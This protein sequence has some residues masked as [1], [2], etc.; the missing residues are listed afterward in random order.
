MLVL[1]HD[2]RISIRLLH[3]T[4]VRQ[5]G[6]NNSAFV[7]LSLELFLLIIALKDIKKVDI[8][9]FKGQTNSH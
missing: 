9:V 6:R 8:A 7:L 3:A 4:S 2:G 5:Y 1:A